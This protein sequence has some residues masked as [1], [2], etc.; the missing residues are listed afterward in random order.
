MKILH[1]LV[2]YLAVTALPFHPFAFATP[3]A[4]NYDGYVDTSQNNTDGALTKHVLRIANLLETCKTIAPH[5]LSVT[6]AQDHS[7]SAALMKRTPPSQAGDDIEPRLVPEVVV[8]SVIV[9]A[10]VAAI[11]LSIF[12]NEL[13]NT[14]SDN[15]VRDNDVEFLVEHPDQRSSCQKREKFTKSTITGMMP[16]YPIVNWII[17]HTDHFVLFDG[18]E[19]TDYGHTHHELEVSFG[20]TIG[21]VPLNVFLFFFLFFLM[22]F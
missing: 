14:D 18:D 17:C 19:G 13:E 10:I 9:I 22:A 1:A 6:S 7:D 12:L 11:A 15:K 5:S 8:V 21:S 16:H 3:A 2:G 20:R 4:T